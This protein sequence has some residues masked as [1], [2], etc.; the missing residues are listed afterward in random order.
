MCKA[1]VTRKEDLVPSAASVWWLPPSTRPAFASE[2]VILN[3]PESGWIVSDSDMPATKPFVFVL[4]PFSDSFRDTYQF[5]IKQACEELGCYCERVDEQIYHESM[6]ARIYNQI[7]KAD[8]LVADMSERNPNVFYEVG[9]AHG[10][11]KKVI[12]LTRDSADIPFDLKHFP[13][14]VY[15]GQI[16]KLKQELSRQVRW[17]TENPER[18]DELMVSSLE[19]FLDDRRVSD[20]SS[21]VVKFGKH[22]GGDKSFF[23]GSWR[24]EIRVFNSPSTVARRQRFRI[25]F[26]MPD[27]VNYFY[28][29]QPKY[30]YQEATLPSGRKVVQLSVEFD[31]IPGMFESF[32]TGFHTKR[33]PEL[34]AEDILKITFLQD[35][36]PI[37]THVR[38]LAGS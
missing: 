16:T 17:L 4:M 9:Y 38:I 33:V 35:S 25:S 34:P 8:I 14:I 22:S 6:L 12:L 5:G 18:R 27:W 32:E 15:G 23:I 19:I 36:G 29:E 31:L 3:S 26:E 7:G 10:L 20:D 28:I 2:Q 1:R 24:R 13:H 30:E 11:G 37:A 21:I